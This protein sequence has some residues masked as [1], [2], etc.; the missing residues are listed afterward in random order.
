MGLLGAFALLGLQHFDVVVGDLSNVARVTVGE[1]G[2]QGAQDGLSTYRGPGLL[3]VVDEVVHDVAL[4][5]ELVD[6]DHVLG[7]RAAARKLVGELL[8]RL[9]QVHVCKRRPSDATR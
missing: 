8:G 1:R 4:D 9:F 5:H 3:D 7:D 6:A 2:S